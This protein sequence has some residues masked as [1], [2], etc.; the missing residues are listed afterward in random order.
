MNKLLEALWEL[1]APATA[2]LWPDPPD[3]KSQLV[4]SVLVLSPRASR[5]AVGALEVAL[6]EGSLDDAITRLYELGAQWGQRGEHEAAGGCW[7][8]ADVI[9]EWRNRA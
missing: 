7:E 8:L 6:A 2:I 5:L 1:E 4:A 3:L 9:R